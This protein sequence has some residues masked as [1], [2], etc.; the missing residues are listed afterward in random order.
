MAAVDQKK[1]DGRRGIME[2]EMNEKSEVV[3]N[4]GVYSCPFCGSKKINL[5]TQAVLMK[6]EDANTG[7]EVDA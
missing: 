5:C 1:W 6:T 7:K 2:E 4:D 3:E